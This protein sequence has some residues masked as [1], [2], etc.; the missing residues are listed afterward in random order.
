MFD[1]IR[2]VLVE[3][4]H[5]GNIGGVARAMKTMGFSKLYLVAPKQFPHRKADELASG[6]Q[7]VLAQAKVVTTLNEAIHDCTL[8]VGSSARIRSIPWPLLWP[9]AMAEKVCKDSLSKETVALL[10]GREQSGLTNEELQHCHLHVQIPAASDYSSLNLA[11]AV[12]VIAYEMRM[13]YLTLT[14]PKGASTDLATQT[15]MQ[16]FFAHLEQVL[17]DIHFLKMNASRQLTTR[18]RRLFL[19][20]HPEKME[21]NLLRGILTAIQ[22]TIRSIPS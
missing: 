17:V 12:Q 2:I 8:V 20:M 10:F 11:S 22:K 18:L 13:A 5:P 7:D 15:D 21:I 16:H 14:V 4:S 1:H 3:P 19:R 6:A 9:K